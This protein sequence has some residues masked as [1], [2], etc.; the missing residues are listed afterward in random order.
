Q[1]WDVQYILGEALRWHATS[2]N[3]KSRAIP[4]DW[5]AA[6]EEFQKRMGYRLELR[7]FEYPAAVKPGNAMPIKMVWGHLGGGPVECT[8]P[9]APQWHNAPKNVEVQVPSDL[10]KWLPGDAV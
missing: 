8:C 5:K 7:R 10:R 1:G 4:P 6:F 9:P 3:V 2:L